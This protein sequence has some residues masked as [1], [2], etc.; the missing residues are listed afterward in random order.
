MAEP[1]APVKKFQWKWV[2]ISF[3]SYVFFY[4]LPLIIFGHTFP[5]HP[6]VMF[7]FVTWIFVGIIVVA[8][9]VAYNSE[10]VTIWEPAVAVFLLLALGLAWEAIRL[11]SSPP[12]FR[13]SMFRYFQ[14]FVF[15]GAVA[16]VLS[17]FGAWFGERAQKLWRKEPPPSA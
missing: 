5:H 16:L 17:L 14:P 10:D 11:F 12:R 9:V 4:I 13:I 8:G 7:L 3:G 6:V 15:Q 1:T 2:W